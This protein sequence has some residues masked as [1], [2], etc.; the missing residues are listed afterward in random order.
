M[1]PSPQERAQAIAAR[2]RATQAPAAREW[3]RIERSG[4]SVDVFFCPAQT[5]REVMDRW[6]PGAGV[7]AI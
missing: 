7:R 2:A 5:Q 4:E 1:Q 3:W 6:Y